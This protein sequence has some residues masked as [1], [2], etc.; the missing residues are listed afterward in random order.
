MPSLG[1]LDIAENLY[2]KYN[3]IIL[4]SHLNDRINIH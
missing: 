2:H 3:N 1:D 4:A